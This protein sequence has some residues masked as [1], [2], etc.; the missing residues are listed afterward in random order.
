MSEF[1]AES[2][3]AGRSLRKREFYLYAIGVTDCKILCARR[4]QEVGSKTGRSKN[5]RSQRCEC[6][7]IRNTD[8][9]RLQTPGIRGDLR[10]APAAPDVKTDMV[11]IPARREEQGPRI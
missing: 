7:P 1:Q 6:G 3:A 10:D 9:K 4:L 2:S 11:M 8:A 5:A